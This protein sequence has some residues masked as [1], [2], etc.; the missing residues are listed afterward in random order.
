[1]L[2]PQLTRNWRHG[3]QLGNVLL[4]LLA[5]GLWLHGQSLGPNALVLLT[6]LTLGL[7]VSWSLP[8]VTLNGL[9]DR[10]AP[11][12]TD[13]VVTDVLYLG[14]WLILPAHFNVNTVG[15]GGLALSMVGVTLG[16]V[17]RNRIWG[18]RLPSTLASATLWHQV[19]TASGRLFLV[20]GWGLLLIS[21][22]GGAV[23]GMATL[24]LAV[25]LLGG[26]LWANY[27]YQMR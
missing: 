5:W 26:S 11:L 15:W 20:G 10:M 8:Y 6:G 4:L 16:Y 13:L 1:M 14:T 25:I 24:V 19:N 17:P 7:L 18:V 12:A 21:R 22:L 9:Q 2:I 3:L 27:Y 23:V